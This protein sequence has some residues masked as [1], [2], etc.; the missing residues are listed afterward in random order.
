MM[1]KII[2]T[3]FALA[4]GIA[5]GGCNKYDYKEPVQ[6]LFIVESDVD[7]TAVGG[8]GTILVRTNREGTITASSNQDWCTVEVLGMIVKVTASQNGQISNRTAMVTVSLG[9]ESQEVPVTQSASYFSIEK[10]LV[11][12][13]WQEGIYE[14]GLQS[15]IT[16]TITTDSDW[17]TVD[18]SA[19][20]IIIT[21]G[22]NPDNESREG[23]VTVIIGDTTMTIVV[24]QARHPNP[25]IPYADFPTQWT[26]TYYDQNGKLRT[27]TLTFTPVAPSS[28]NVSG[29]TG[30]P[31][32]IKLDYDQ[33]T[34]DLSMKMGQ[35]I[36]RGS[37][38]I[39][40]NVAIDM[41]QSMWS[42]SE[43]AELAG[44]WIGT[45]DAPEYEFGD[46]GSVS[47]F[48]VDGWSW[49]QFE[50]NEEQ[51]YL[52]VFNITLYMTMVPV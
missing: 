49:G 18:L 52:N 39:Y 26:L 24:K 6:T 47:G 33:E 43:Q 20:S 37:G 19:E 11:E 10:L 1:K 17:I 12:A 36:L 9:D 28:F 42:K 45:I 4:A 2:Y 50:D 15:V 16:P 7:F 48:H 8:E 41:A 27:A 46:T 13:K 31:S 21:V 35:E 23:T 25:P 51:A 38:Y 29:W 5:V 14:V 32:F 3:I 30:L 44:F 40:F 22:E 34:G